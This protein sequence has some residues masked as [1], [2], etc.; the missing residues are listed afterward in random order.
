MNGMRDAVISPRTS[1]SKGESKRKLP[2]WQ[3][4]IFPSRKPRASFSRALTLF[5]SPCDL[6]SCGHFR[7]LSRTLLRP[8]RRRLSLQRPPPVAFFLFE[9]KSF[10]VLKKNRASHAIR[11][12]RYSRN[13]ATGFEKAGAWGRVN[14]GCEVVRKR[15]NNRRVQEMLCYLDFLYRCDSDY[16]HMNGHCARKYN[17]ITTYTLSRSSWREKMRPWYS[18]TSRI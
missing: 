8:E 5:P 15:E 4:S 16:G 9:T 10:H 1:V 17:N 11:H 7:Q 14:F 13:L 12:V 6:E 3:R 2:S 18:N